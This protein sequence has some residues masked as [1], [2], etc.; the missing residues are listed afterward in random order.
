MLE[1]LCRRLRQTGCSGA[2]VLL[3]ATVNTRMEGSRAFPRRAVCARK[4][5][6]TLPPCPLLYRGSAEVGKATGVMPTASGAW[7]FRPTSSRT[8]TAG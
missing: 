8:T 2:F 6:P 7:S 4:A 1:P 5:V 3:D